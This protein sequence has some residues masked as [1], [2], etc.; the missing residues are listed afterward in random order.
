MPR[1]RRRNRSRR[2]AQVVQGPNPQVEEP[3]A[4]SALS[5]RILGLIVVAVLFGVAFMVLEGDS[6]WELRLVG[7]GVLVL[8]C[9]LVFGWLG[10]GAKF[11][12]ALETSRMFSISL[13]FQ[14]AGLMYAN[15]SD[16]ILA[17][18]GFTPTMW[19]ITFAL[20]VA[21]YWLVLYLARRWLWWFDS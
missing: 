16:L 2:P 19:A 12:V 14:L 3:P 15:R 1:K 11:A 17:M 10:K 4:Q 9:V 13:P 6:R 5:P 7:V 20:T 8:T 18:P 21:V